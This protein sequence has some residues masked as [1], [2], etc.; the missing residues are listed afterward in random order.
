MLNHLLEEKNKFSK[1]LIDLQYEKN[2]VLHNIVELE[3]K[4]M[5]L[6]ISP[7]RIDRI[8]NSVLSS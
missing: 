7:E 5:K 1:P 4:L 8:K 6:E 2:N 3:S